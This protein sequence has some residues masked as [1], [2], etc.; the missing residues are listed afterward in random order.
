F[1][2]SYTL[3]KAKDNGQTSNAFPATNTPLD[4][5]NPLSGESGTSNFDIRHKF[6]ASAV[7]T[8]DFFGDQGESKV[9]HAI[10]NGFSIAPIFQYY[11]GRPLN[12]GT[13]G[14]VASQGGIS[15]AAGGI[16]GSAGAA[17]FPGALRNSFRAPKAWNM[18]LRI[19]RRFHFGESRSLELLAEGFNIFNRTQTTDVNNTL[20]RVG[21][22]SNVPGCTSS[23]QLCLNADNAGNSLFG[24]ITEAGGTLFRERQVQLAVRFQF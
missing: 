5:F 8:P 17:R 18:D 24:T 15:S 20:Y 10:F 22:Q 14:S 21:P 7:W 23:A 9:G 2:A 11:S 16:N 12:P 13:A 4:P 3:A 1:Q 19:S 6:V